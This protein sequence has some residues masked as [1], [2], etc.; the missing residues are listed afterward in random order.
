MYSMSTSDERQ[1]LSPATA[2]SLWDAWHCGARRVTPL[3]RSLDY[4]PAR[5]SLRSSRIAP[6]TR[7]ALGLIRGSLDIPTH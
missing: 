1:S 3:G 7:F 2:R 4:C 6:A 5:R